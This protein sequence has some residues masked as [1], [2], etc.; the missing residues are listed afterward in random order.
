[1][2][3]WPAKTI[4][5]TVVP[6]L[7]SDGAKAYGNRGMLFDG[8]VDGRRLVKR[9]ATPFCDT[10]RILLA[11]GIKPSTPFLMRHEGSASDALR[12]TVAV[13][14][15]LT[16]WDDAGGKPIFG[17]WK[18]RE[19]LDGASPMRESEPPATLVPDAP[20]RVQEPA[21]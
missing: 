18:P 11:E 3:I 10:A 9:S 1:M 17:R 20:E 21:Q 4:V 7:N 13:A 12:S 14:A 5:L 19:A 15:K 16:V 6:S 8:V 2:T